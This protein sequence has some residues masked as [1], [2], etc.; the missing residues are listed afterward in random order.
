MISL[1]T[2][3]HKT[4]HQ[5]KVKPAIYGSNLDFLNP[6]MNTHDEMQNVS[7]AWPL[8]LWF[9]ESIEHSQSKYGCGCEQIMIG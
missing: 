1:H 9:H 4:S 2:L 6:C 5:G 8:S 7:N 3:E